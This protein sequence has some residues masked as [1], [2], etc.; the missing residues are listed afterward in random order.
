M[1]AEYAD[2]DAVV[3]GGGLAGAA[4]ACH[5]AAAKKS[6][7]LLEKETG[8]RHKVCGEFISSE[9]QGYL[10]ALGIDLAGLGA[11]PIRHVRLVHGRRVAETALP[12]AAAGLSRYR[13]DEAL[14][15]RANALGVCVR[16]GTTVRAI[17]KTNTDTWRVM[18]GEESAASA[19]IF[20][21]TGKHELRQFKRV[22][23]TPDGL[24][25]F[26]MYFRLARAQTEALRESVEV[27]LFDGG[28]AGLQ[29]IDSTTAN[30]CLLVR[31]STFARVGKSWPALL[32]HL[33]ASCAHLGDR[34]ASAVP[35]WEEPLAITALPFG[36]LGTEDRQDAGIYRLGDQ[37]SVI[38]AFSGNGISIALHTARLAADCYLQGHDAAEYL[39]IVRRDLRDT[40]GLANGLARVTA[41]AWAQGLTVDACRVFPPLM[42]ILARRTRIPGLAA[43][44]R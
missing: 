18:A 4:V 25:G 30:L 32:D 43:R 5:L 22:P 16:R 34:L 3:V 11:V 28:Y 40:M 39:R 21:A 42:A 20:L 24:I 35:C 37:V 6:V 33:T 8:P 27:I 9:A 29:L 26:K 36:F 10:A 15:G 12:F 1:S 13:L 44:A 23:A 41:H 38:P 7:L 17:E 19:A 31:K 2:H 14:L